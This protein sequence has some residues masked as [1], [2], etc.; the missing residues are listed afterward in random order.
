MPPLSLTESESEGREVL[1]NSSYKTLQFCRCFAYGS[2]EGARGSQ[3]W[4]AEPS[5]P[6]P[7]SAW[8][9]GTRMC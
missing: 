3:L 7:T 8:A 2:V 1:R 4:E 6:S 9:G 5:G